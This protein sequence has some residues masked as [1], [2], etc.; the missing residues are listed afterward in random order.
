MYIWVFESK[1]ISEKQRSSV[2]SDRKAGDEILGNSQLKP[3][4]RRFPADFASTILTA[5]DQR[6]LRGNVTVFKTCKHVG[7]I[8]F[9]NKN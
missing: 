5:F 1:R 3:V 6:L 7:A 9:I 8:K 2:I 4:T